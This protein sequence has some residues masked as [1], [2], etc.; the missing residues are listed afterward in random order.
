[1]A[2]HGYIG[3]APCGCVFAVV[4]DEADEHTAA[5]VAE[6]IAD[7]AHVERLTADECRG[8]FAMTPCPHN[9]RWGGMDRNGGRLF[10]NAND[11]TELWRA[12]RS[13]SETVLDFYERRGL[14]RYIADAAGGEPSDAWWADVRERL[15]SGIGAALRLLPKPNSEPAEP[16]SGQMTLEPTQGPHDRGAACGSET[17]TAGPIVT[18][19]NPGAES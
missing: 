14:G 9:P 16:S 19:A 3:I 15:E 12:I 1:M 7:G 2:T 10:P 11:D 18:A 13:S 8:R 6:W 5:S 4:T 17:S